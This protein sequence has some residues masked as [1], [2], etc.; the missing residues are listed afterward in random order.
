MLARLTHMPL[1]QMPALQVSSEK[2]C[3][4]LAKPMSQLRP[5]ASMQNMSSQHHDSVRENNGSSQ[6]RAA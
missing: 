3:T 5:D 1:P 6:R 4:A 2:Y